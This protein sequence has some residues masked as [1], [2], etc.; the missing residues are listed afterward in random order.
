M[1]TGVDMRVL[2][3]VGLLTMLAAPAWAD[4]HFVAAASWSENVTHTNDPPVHDDDAHL[5]DQSDSAFAMLGHEGTTTLGVS[6]EGSAQASASPGGLG[7]LTN[8]QGTISMFALDLEFRVDALARLV[9]DD[10]HFTGPSGATVVPTSLNVR[11]DA[12][13]GVDATNSSGGENDL[14]VQ[15]ELATHHAT[16]LFVSDF[17]PPGQDPGVEIVPSGVSVVHNVG[18][19]EIDHFASMT[20]IDGDFVTCA[21]TVPL[22]V[23]QTL[24]LS[25]LMS[26][27]A[28][29]NIGFSDPTASIILSGDALHTLALP[30]TGPVF[31][32]PDGYSVSSDSGLIVDNQL[33]TTVSS[34]T[35]TTMPVASCADR[36]G[37]DAVDC[38]CA[39]G[40]PSTCAG[41]TLPPPVAKGFPKACT[42]ADSA[43]AAT[44]RKARRLF[45]R[46]SKRLAK[47]THVV[48]RHKIAAKLSTECVAGL[49]SLFG[50]LHDRV[51]ALRP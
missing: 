50:D 48:G 4:V 9:L 26:T 32:L 13:L 29:G 28:G 17:D 38:E 33:V 10:L 24:M 45:T 18:A 11:V 27:F 8:A 7:V 40:A 22:G 1:L 31:N 37:I 41:L 15:C 39:T 46:A 6:D 30:A 20:T 25:F 21:T 36:P 35:T 47:L 44:G 19:D 3:T 12:L 2:L 16:E 51:L 14:S 23:P 34:T 42:T 49:Q 5:V 43:A